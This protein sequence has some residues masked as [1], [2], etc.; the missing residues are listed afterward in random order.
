VV[1]DTVKKAEDSDAFV[2]RLFE[3][4]GG[5][6]HVTLQSALFSAKAKAVKVDLLEQGSEAVR[7]TAQGI[8]LALKPFEVVTLKVSP[9]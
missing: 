2:L 6:Q 4:H 3:S 8:K 7:V 5:N 9:A 1:L